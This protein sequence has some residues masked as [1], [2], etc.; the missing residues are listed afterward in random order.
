MAVKYTLDGPLLVS[1]NLTIKAATGRSPWQGIK[2]AL[3]RCGG[4]NNKPFCDGSHKET[5]FKS[6]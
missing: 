3:Y 1:S 5:E 6:D 4:S 2:I